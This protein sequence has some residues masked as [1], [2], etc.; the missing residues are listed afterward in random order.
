MGHLSGKS[1]YFDLQRRLDRMPIGAPQHRALVAIQPGEIDW[2]SQL[3]DAV[4]RALP[5]AA[6][7]VAGLVRRWSDAAGST[8]LRQQRSATDNQPMGA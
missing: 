2:G 7:R 8:R 1:A 6:G 5:E 3:S 4:E